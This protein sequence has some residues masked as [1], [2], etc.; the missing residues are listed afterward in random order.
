[1]VGAASHSGAAAN[2]TTEAA[3]EASA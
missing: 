2:G 1:V 3:E